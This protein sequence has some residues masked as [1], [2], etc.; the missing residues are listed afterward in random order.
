M[1][2][3][4]REPAGKETAKNRPSQVRFMKSAKELFQA[5]ET[6]C[7]SKEDLGRRVSWALDKSNEVNSPTPQ[8]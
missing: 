4:K 6:F 3:S 7:K 2:P 1:L 5:Y 8:E